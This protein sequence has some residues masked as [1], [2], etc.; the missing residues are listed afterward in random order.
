[1]KRIIRL[2]E[3]DLKRIVRRVIRE[4]ESIVDPCK[5]KVDALS[6]LIGDRSKISSC[7][8]SDMAEKCVT[9][10]VRMIAQT[11]DPMVISAAKALLKCRKDNSG[12]RIKY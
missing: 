6:K 9:D 4:E 7:A 8:G 10:L 12:V 2:T 11:T 5:D 1:M 3:S